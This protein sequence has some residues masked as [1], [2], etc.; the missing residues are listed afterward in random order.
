MKHI[1][2]FL[3]TVAMALTAQRLSAET[4]YAYN[5]GAWDDPENWTVST[6]GTTYDNPGK[7]TPGAGDTAIIPL[8][9]SMT[10]TTEATVSDLTLNGQLKISG[11]G[12]LTVNGTARGT[13]LLITEGLN[14]CWFG[15]NEFTYSGTVR[16]TG[17]GEITIDNGS[18]EY[19]DVEIAGGTV[20]L[21]G[22]ATI[23]VRGNLTMTGGTV[24]LADATCLKVWGNLSLTNDAQLQG[25]DVSVCSIEVCGNLT[26]GGNARLTLASGTQ[27]D[28]ANISS[29][30]TLKFIGAGDQRMEM[31]SANAAAIYRL[32]CDKPEGKQLTVLGTAGDVSPLFYSPV[33]GSADEQPVVL[34]GGILKLGDN[35]KIDKW[36]CT[37]YSWD[38]WGGFSKYGI[39]IPEKTELWI[40]GATIDCGSYYSDHL[41][42]GNMKVDGTLR[43]SSGSLNLP[44]NSIGIYYG[45]SASAPASV[46]IEGGT[47]TTTGLEPYS[48][49]SSCLY[50]SQLDGTLSISNDKQQKQQAAF[51]ME[52]T[53]QTFKMS[54][55][56]I[57]IKNV[58]G[59]NGKP[60]M[61][62]IT[63]VS[64]S[65]TGGTI[66]LCPTNLGKADKIMF[67]SVAPFWNLKIDG[68]YTVK[69]DSPW[70][71]FDFVVQNDL[72]CLGTSTLAIPSTSTLYLGRNLYVESGSTLDASGDI[73]LDGSAAATIT[74]QS[75]RC[76]FANCTISKDAAETTVTV[77]DGYSLNIAGNLTVTN[78]E[79]GG[80]IVLSG[81][82]QSISS[83]RGNEGGLD[84][85][86]LC[87]NTADQA[88]TLLSDIRAKKLNS[89]ARNTVSIGDH[90]LTLTDGCAYTS[91][92][93]V[94]TDGS[95]SA[96][97]LTLPLAANGTTTFPL[98]VSGKTESYACAATSKSSNV[99]GL[100]TVSV[101][102]DQH[103]LTIEG[104][105]E[106][107][108][109]GYW[110]VYFAGTYEANGMTLKFN[111]PGLGTKGNG[112]GQN[113]LW[114]QHRAFK[115]WKSSGTTTNGGTITFTNIKDGTFDGDYT[116]A[117]NQ[118]LGNTDAFYSAASG[119][120]Y[121]NIWVNDPDDPNAQR[122]SGLEI[123]G[124]SELIVRDGHTVTIRPY[125]EYDKKG[126][127]ETRNLQAA[128]LEIMEGGTVVV[129]ADARAKI[130]SM[131]GGKGGPQQQ[132]GIITGDGTLIYKVD[133]GWDDGR[134]ISGLDKSN[135]LQGD[136]KPFCQSTKATWIYEV[137]SG[138]FV[139]PASLNVY[140]NLTVRP[141]E[142]VSGA[143]VL[144]SNNVP[145]TFTVNGNLTVAA[146]GGSITLDNNVGW[147]GTST[148][149]GNIS[150]DSGCAYESSNGAA[151]YTCYGSI[152]NNGSF[153]NEANFYLYGNLTQN[154]TL[155][156]TGDFYF[157]GSA[158]ATMSGS[159]ED[160]ASNKF[161]HI[162]VNKDLATTEVTFG[163]PLS[164]NDGGKE[165]WL[166]LIKGVAHMAHKDMDIEVV[167]K[168][169]QWNTLN[170]FKIPSAT[171]L[172]VDKGGTVAM[173][174]TGDASG[175]GLWLDGTL[176]LTGGSQDD[177]STVTVGSGIGYTASTSS[178]LNVGTHSTLT[179]QSI[180]PFDKD[181]SLKFSQT[182]A[183]STIELKGSLGVTGKAVLDI[184]GGSF[185]QEQQ[186]RISIAGLSNEPA[187]M[188]TV[189]FAPDVTD[190]RSGS[191]IAICHGQGGLSAGIYSTQ[192]L[193][194]VE[195]LSAAHMESALTLKGKLTVA[196]DFVA[197]NQG[198]EVFDLTLDADM[199]QRGSGLYDAKGN[200]TYLTASAAQ[201]ISATGTNGLTF[202]NV[203][204]TGQGNATATA[205]TV[206]GTLR[207]GLGTLTLGGAWQ[208]LG[209]VSIE[210]KTAVAGSGELTLCKT[211]AAQTLFCEG[212]VNYLTINNHN[213]VESTTTQSLPI[214]IGK[215]LKLSSGNLNIGG[216]LL[217]LTAEAAIV[218]DA[219]GTDRFGTDRM[220]VT[221]QSQTDRGIRKHLPAGA[222]SAVL[223]MGC[224]QKYTP[225]FISV[226]S[227]T[228][229]DEAHI[230]IAPSNERHASL[231]EDVAALQFYW[232]V[233]SQGVSGMNGTISL[234]DVL[235]DAKDY[236]ENEDTYGASVLLNTET[237]WRQFVGDGIT[238]NGDRMTV[239][240]DFSN[241]GDAQIGGDY[242]AGSNFPDIKAYIS[243]ADGEA[244][245]ADVWKTYDTENGA[246]GDAL[247]LTKD[248]MRGCI[249]FVQ[250]N[251]KVTANEIRLTRM[252][253]MND[254]VLDLGT[255]KNHNFC[256][257]M[258]QG[259]LYVESGAMPSTSQYSFFENGGGTVE[260]GGS[261]NYNVMS[262]LP[263][264]NNVIFSGSGTRT[265]T[266]SGEMDI[267]GTLTVKGD[268]QLTVS[269]GIRVNSDMTVEGNGKISGT[270]SVNLNGT[271]RQTLTAPDGFEMG[272]PLVVNNASGIS[273]A[274]NLTLSSSLTLT[275][276]IVS[277]GG[278]KL[279]ISN[280]SLS[281]LQ[282]GSESSYVDGT[283]VKKMYSNEATTF[284][285]GDGSRY[286]AI[287]LSSQ[288]ADAFEVSYHD[289]APL[290]SGSLNGINSISKNEYWVVNSSNASQARVTLRWDAF[291]AITINDNLKIASFV[292]MDGN[293]S[294][295]WEPNDIDRSSLSTNPTSGS[296]R[297][298]SPIVCQGTHLTFA[299]ATIELAY[300]WTGAESS[301]WFAAGNWANR[302]VPGGGSDVTI[303]GTATRMPVIAGSEVA[304]VNDVEIGSGATLTLDG[305]QMT[306][307]GE[308]KGNGEFV[309]NYHSDGM[310]SFINKGTSTPQVTVNRTFATARLW[311]VGGLTSASAD[312]SSA[313][314]S[315]Q[316]NGFYNANGSGGDCLSYYSHDADAFK[317]DSNETFLYNAGG[318]GI[319]GTVG[320]VANPG[321][322]VKE[323]TRT[324]TEK[325]YLLNPGKVSIDVKP[326]TDKHFGWYLLENP[327]PF[328]LSLSNDVFSYGEHVS[329]VIWFRSKNSGGYFFATFNYDLKVGV[330]MP[331]TDNGQSTGLDDVSLAPGQ[332]FY[333]KVVDNSDVFTIDG[334]KPSH[335]S[336]TRLKSAGSAPA[337]VL[338]LCI[339]SAEANTD[340]TAMV[341][342]TGGT[343]GTNGSD[344]GK[345]SESTSY[346]QIY[347]IKDKTSNAIGL[348]PETSVMDEQ[349]IPL[350]VSVSKKSSQAVITAS[351]IELFDAATDVY[352][353][354]GE[355]GEMISLRDQPQYE[356]DMKAGTGS[357]SRFAIV[358]R[359]VGSQQDES[360][361]GATSI[362]DADDADGSISI[363]SSLGHVSISVS[364]SLLERNPTAVIHDMTGRAVIS[365]SIDNVSTTIGLGDAS[366]VYVVE[367]TAGEERR[368]AKIRVGAR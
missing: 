347:T 8:G 208:A 145:L 276:G 48:A 241:A 139:V 18:I 116:A 178:T 163:L 339:S 39:Q 346:N 207:V 182:S 282:G 246:T 45:G 140:P 217:E 228:S 338:R 265:I 31:G 103:P 238:V 341:F 315:S 306:L 53:G 248:E 106:N 308:I 169:Y 49:G 227:H 328:T 42:Y 95:Y 25:S 195:V 52:T 360:E 176:T 324:I 279:T 122:K 73:I 352:L 21:T 362:A 150:I 191:T 288:A 118:T 353:L 37:N 343:L 234:E 198:G 51:H 294:G 272:A 242:T 271:A 100:L 97:G 129:E 250:H 284:P 58:S 278:N 344:A 216:N 206:G 120:W 292:N 107:V 112:N 240:F 185:T 175:A 332:A 158:E 132:D 200:T 186:T 330:N 149:K 161:N 287:V 121:E 165:I 44:E 74:D 209:D 254:G 218:D 351:N 148:I 310:A 9:K 220:I 162:V 245:G 79:L 350:G 232:T 231:G 274:R 336:G 136:H 311:Y 205:A 203:D 34:K 215:Q 102:A 94:M 244:I 264:V 335:T 117:S 183:T 170:Y 155:A 319:G 354:D 113:T 258:G 68:S 105:K 221:N 3:M 366:G 92:P 99:S 309:I 262:Q 143:K 367:V 156:S 15:T 119:N 368:S 50:Y 192:P 184:R 204:K 356:F 167:S 20:R 365:R 72:S 225:A 247:S 345:R 35:V 84:N 177:N 202:G 277:T 127:S 41:L 168:Y 160:A 88:L 359:Y 275:D 123:R 65:V 189:R 174:K 30:V 78:G 298:N 4:F 290:N 193:M 320:L 331:L 197:S 255:T 55:G 17:T 67:R 152:E 210:A 32:V 326:F 190:L 104:Q 212:T 154:G 86:V 243:V 5:D 317:Y 266:R 233:T 7:L 301:D 267:Y 171:S 260:F 164:N 289:A 71:G 325:G 363:S 109:D 180:M 146:N 57:V 157:V 199:E 12:K 173:T 269:S 281:A 89:T 64:S 329:P 187:T 26:T 273:I 263:H 300:L 2:I 81:S 138:D 33:T 340:E 111:A 134:W 280:A 295:S 259:K 257:L 27:Y 43:I 312:R 307:F 172:I 6:A 230:T 130:V 125:I 24:A 133:G 249:F 229:A 357:D 75:G 36:G 126:N 147:N 54:G 131:S 224:D 256:N 144:T 11:A 96:G 226:T 128:G 322:G 61:L 223:P 179:A 321:T 66:T 196:A 13:G 153:Q 56:E 135:Y 235:A 293:A 355:T 201:S 333:I 286:G 237:K 10:L 80:N 327:F 22:G 110:Q 151:T 314:A 188:P 124:A 40:A 194:A 16:Y 69:M 364:E 253:I 85:A 62:Y 213:G 236:E 297:S 83:A 302:T 323:S 252:T 214:G 70:N 222:F 305:G 137:Q 141:K 28:D 82:S 47:I 159:A 251:I 299:A 90:N 361:Q 358:L 38:S 268:A 29:R 219:G 342:R 101:S 114:G 14:S 63:D 316:V 59:N 211:D 60:T 349:V 142:G 304:L 23:N 181:G 98:G 313:G 296:V 348:Y 239:G 46:I 19:N 337:D 285:V 1:T 291:S 76:R 270:G 87:M 318:I 283:I 261:D 108:Y 91:L 115:E 166:E 93:L 77:A 334:S 303:S